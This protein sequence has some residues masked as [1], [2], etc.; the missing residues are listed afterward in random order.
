VTE[1][2][3]VYDEEDYYQA[4]QEAEMMDYYD[5]M[6]GGSLIDRLGPAEALEYMNQHV[7]NPVHHQILAEAVERIK[8]GTYGEGV[9]L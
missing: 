5:A 3:S 2:V 7:L 9:E 6:D 8:T 4:E 1:G